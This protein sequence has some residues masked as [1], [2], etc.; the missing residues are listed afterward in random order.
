MKRVTGFSLSESI[1]NELDSRRGDIPRS[2]MVERILFR[3]F[4]MEP[5]NEATRIV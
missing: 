4:S 5:E 3:E 2:R 1:L